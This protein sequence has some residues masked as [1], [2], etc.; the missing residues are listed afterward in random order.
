MN[1]GAWPAMPREKAVHQDRTYKLLIVTSFAAAALLG[2]ALL[3]TALADCPDG[4]GERMLMCLFVPSELDLGTHLMSYSFFGAVLLSA[5]SGVLLWRRQFSGFHRMTMNLARLEVPTGELAPLA[6]RLGLEGRLCVVDSETPLSFCAGFRRPRIYVSR[7][8]VARLNAEELE[9]LLIHERHHLANRVP[10]KILTG[11]FVSSIL[12]FIPFFRDLFERYIIEEE[13]AA[14]ESAIRQ[15][16]HQRGIAGILEKLLPQQ[17]PDPVPGLAA[18]ATGALTFRIDHL[19]GK[20]TGNAWHFHLFH[21]A[22]SVAVTTFILAAILHPST[23]HHLTVGS[24]SG[25]LHGSLG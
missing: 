15:Q 4:C 21:T 14:D 16:G 17:V 22:I 8:M 6:R 3:R 19:L 24:I 12:F 11:R 5:A 25:W 9:A 7:G 1:C 2:L 20:E 10:L 13:I 23:A 18:G